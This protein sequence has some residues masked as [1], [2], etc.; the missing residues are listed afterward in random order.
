MRS[1]TWPAC[2]AAIL[3]AGFSSGAQA[4]VVEYLDDL[5]EIELAAQDQGIEG[6]FSPAPGAGLPVL[7]LENAAAA[8]HRATIASVYCRAYKVDNP[9]SELLTKLVQAANGNLVPGDVSPG[10]DGSTASIAIDK[11][12][13]LMRCFSVKELKALCK[14]RVRISA[15]MNWTD[16]A[17]AAQS[18][19]LN[20]EVEREGRV[21][22]F[23]GHIA[24]FIGIVSREAGIAMIDEARAAYAAD[25]NEPEQ[26]PQVL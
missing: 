13:T 2:A 11:A 17:G 14:A 8:D 22:G 7:D 1:A 3:L 19:P 24:R 4:R 26:E 10:Q 6:P 21:G 15:S 20:V 9:V 25:R 18:V 16:G 5:E 23:C 12:A